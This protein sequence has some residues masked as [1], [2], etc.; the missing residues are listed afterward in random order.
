MV[1]Q[2]QPLIRDL[3]FGVLDGVMAE[4]DIQP[5]PRKRDHVVLPD[6][7]F[8]E[9]VQHS[10]WWLR[11]NDTDT[12]YRYKRYRDILKHVELTDMRTVHVDIGCG[13]GAFSWA[14]LDCIRSNGL[15]LDRVGL[16]GFDHSPEMINLAHRMRAGLMTDV[17][18]YPELHYTNNLNNLLT[19]VRESHSEPTMYLITFGHVL[20]Q[21]SS[22]EARLD[23]IGVIYKILEL[24]G[25][26]S[27]CVAIAV[28]ARKR[29]GLAESWRIILGTLTKKLGVS[30]NQIAIPN[31]R[32]NG[33]LSAKIARLSLLSG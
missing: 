2:S 5:W 26:D 13:G 14:F 18:N 11:R 9:V 25:S 15:S 16:Y 1:S 10:D 33:P 17:E 4:Y 19:E 24:M 22:K 12:Y 30:Q 20:I 6:A 31:G 32:Y 28:D 21:A 27:C 7:G 8:T 3:Y 23:F 29:I